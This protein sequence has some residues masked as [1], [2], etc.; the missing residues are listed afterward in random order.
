MYPN[1]GS[2]AQNCPPEN[3]FFFHVQLSQLFACVK[4]I[5]EV[6]LSSPF[7]YD[8]FI[9]LL[10]RWQ[11]STL[12][13]LI[14]QAIFSNIL[15]TF[16]FKSLSLALRGTNPKLSCLE[17]WAFV[18]TLPGDYPFRNYRIHLL[19]KSQLR[20][21]FFKIFIKLT[22]QIHNF[23]FGSI[24]FGVFDSTIKLKYFSAAYTKFLPCIM[25]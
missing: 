18:L 1:F 7:H 4:Q 17:Y 9:F 24:H 5:S 8:L 15:K 11:A 25:T 16:S 19:N 22:C 20:M 10:I 6:H 2:K 23:A 13:Q 12:F 3:Q 21:Y 14:E